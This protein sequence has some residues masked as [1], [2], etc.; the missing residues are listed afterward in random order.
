MRNLLLILFVPCGLFAQSNLLSDPDVVWAAE[1][2]QDWDLNPA[3]NGVNWIDPASGNALHPQLEVLVLEAAANK[4]IK[5][6][7]DPECK[8]ADKLPHLDTLIIFDEVT[9]KESTKVVETNPSSYKIIGWRLIQTLYY[10]KKSASWSTS[11]N[12]I[13]PIA[14][15]YGPLFWFKADN[16]Q[17]QIPS[18]EIGWLVRTRNIQKNTKLLNRDYKLVKSS[19]ELP[20]PIDHNI[21]VFQNNAQIPFHGDFNGPV[22]SL[23]DRKS[24]V[25]SSDTVAVFDAKTFEERISIVTNEI[26]SDQVQ[27]LDLF[28]TW[29][30][31]S[32]TSQLGI[33]LD[34]VFPMVYMYDSNGSIRSKQS[35]YCRKSK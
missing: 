31:N 24:R 26:T 19:K 33:Y 6:F 9:Y 5:I 12:A 35:L 30:W 27:E 17:P 22:L 14:E 2:S 28:Q 23:S 3:P 10:H 20:D 32:K 11:V 18:K 4:K 34:A 16:K 8:I 7:K 25:S 21:Q 29:Y 1:F 15:D 13:A